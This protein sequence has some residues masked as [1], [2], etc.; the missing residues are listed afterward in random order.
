[1]VGRT[2]LPSDDVPGAEP[3]IVISHGLWARHFGSDPGAV[4]HTFD[5]SGKRFRVVGVLPRGF[6][7]PK[8]AEV[9]V[10]VLVEFPATLEAEASSASIMV[11]DLVGRLRAGAGIQE[12]RA[13]F[14]TFLREGD[15]QRPPELREMRPVVTTLSDLVV[16]DARARLWIAAGAV[17]L[18]L[19][20]ACV[21]VANLL[22]IRGTARTEELA[23]RSALGAGKRRLFRQ[24]LTESGVLA[25]VAG[26]V[27]ILVAFAMVRG[28]VVL[29]PP[30]LPRREVIGVDAGVLLFALAA[31]CVAALVSGLLPAVLAAKGELG[32]WLRGGARTASGG[33]SAQL[34]RQAL[35]IGQVSLAIIV[36]VG[37]G[38]LVRS[39]VALQNVEMGF[40]DER[41]V[42]VQTEFSASPPERARQIAI[43]EEMVERVRAIPGVAYAASLPRLP[44]SGQGGWSAM[45]TAEGQDSALQA[46]NPWVNFEVV[47]HGYFETLRMPLL[48]GRAFN[49]QDR[50]DAAPVAI[51]TQ[52]VARH[53]WPGMSPVGR[54]IKLGPADGPGEWLTVVGVVG[55]AR[56]RDL[57]EPWPSIYL[58]IRQFAGPVPMSLAVR[59]LGDPG[60]VIPQLR[61]ALEEAHP[62][63]MLVGG[64]PMSQ[65]LAAP[66]AR[67]RFSA[68]LLG[69][70]ATITLLLAAVGLYAVMAA[71]VRQR[72]REIGIR[73]ALGATAQGV[74]RRVMGQGVRLALLGSAIGVAGALMG[75]RLLGSLLFGVDTHDP[76]TFAAVAALLLVTAAL[77]CYIP[78]RRASRVDPVIA[79]KAE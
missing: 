9:W 20:I 71:T 31:T 42:V 45:F 18:L 25:L 8:G 59:T 28:L 69:A 55:E 35:V 73:L 70:F 36:V 57:M 2:L 4:G 72:T 3:V 30:D 27:G 74:Q 22:L 68:F 14:D 13:E 43:Q 40:D 23:I 60:A 44:F 51:V 64:G 6:E 62:E 67:P 48:A 38:L 17:G 79:L 58:P 34:L 21:N 65:L 66:L 7:Y 5:W 15:P 26:V 37:A 39:L 33:R 47:G 24:L 49:E 32:G 16:G 53:A 41:L 46:A 63:L 56:F 75:A 11:F 50:E 61:L 52:S 77:A 19:L 1:V 29:A 10:P 76:A 54:R 78:A 12:A